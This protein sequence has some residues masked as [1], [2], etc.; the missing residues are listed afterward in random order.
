MGGVGN[1]IV[2]EPRAQAE[3]QAVGWRPLIGHEPGSLVLIDG[4]GCWRSKRNAFNGHPRSADDLD[5]QKRF[6]AMVGGVGIIQAGLQLMRAQKMPRSELI[7]LLPFV[8][9]RSACLPVEEPALRR[10]D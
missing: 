5:G 3:R 10:V 2:V 8:A 4:E 6:L 1:V 7:D 9:D